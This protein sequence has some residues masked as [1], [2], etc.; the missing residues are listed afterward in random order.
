MSPEKSVHIKCLSRQATNPACGWNLTGAQPLVQ[1]HLVLQKM[2]A[3]QYRLGRDPSSPMLSHLVAA[4][5]HILGIKMSTS[6]S[7]LGSWMW[8]KETGTNEVVRRLAQFSS[9]SCA[10]EHSAVWCYPAPFSKAPR[11]Q[12]QGEKTRQGAQTQWWQLWYPAAGHLVPLF[13]S[14]K[15]KGVVP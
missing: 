8:P 11:D 5:K 7:L 15:M 2:K 4:A 1:G 14:F 3:A 6:W 13:S 9:L 10:R 12:T